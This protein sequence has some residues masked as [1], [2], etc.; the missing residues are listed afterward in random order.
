[1]KT[2]NNVSTWLKGIVKDFIFQ[3][4]DMVYIDMAGHEVTAPES[5][6]DSILVKYER[7]I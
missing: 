1:M 3:P 7:W 5:L 2:N 4:T 6:H